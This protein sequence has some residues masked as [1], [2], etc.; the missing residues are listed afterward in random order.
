MTNEKTIVSAQEAADLVGCSIRK[1]QGMAK[2]GKISWTKDDRGNYKFDMSELVRVFPKVHATRTEAHTDDNK[3][4]LLAQEVEHL[5][6]MLRVRTQQNDW[7]HGQLELICAEKTRLIDILG[8]NTKLL[9]YQTETKRK[10]ILGI[11]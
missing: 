5:K 3:A 6:E 1:I 7:L 11:F 10:K 4:Q 9:E 8:S 2:H